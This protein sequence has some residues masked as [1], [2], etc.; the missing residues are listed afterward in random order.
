MYISC[1]SLF[2]CLKGQRLN[3]YTVPICNPTSVADEVF[4]TSELAF[5]HEASVH[6]FFREDWTQSSAGLVD[7]DGVDTHWMGGMEVDWSQSSAGLVGVDGVDT[8]VDWSQ[9]SADLVGVDGVDTH[10]M[11]VGCSQSSSLA[12]DGEDGASASGSAATGDK[13]GWTECSKPPV[14]ADGSG[15]NWSKSM[16]TEDSVGGDW[17]EAV[18]GAVKSINTKTNI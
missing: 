1:L 9:S 10:S 16:E 2:Y 8:E 4:W 11:E 7:V 3:N 15:G 5:T 6:C 13:A 17:L 18:L 12:A 14:V